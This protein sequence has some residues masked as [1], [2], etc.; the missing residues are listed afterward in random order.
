VAPGTNVAIEQTPSACV[1]IGSESP[2]TV[3]QCAWICACVS[4]HDYTYVHTLNFKRIVQEHFSHFTDLGRTVTIN[5]F[6]V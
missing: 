4:A 5:E 1:A 2:R 3:I 6:S